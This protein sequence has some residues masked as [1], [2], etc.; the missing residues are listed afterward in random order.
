MSIELTLY[1]DGGARGNPGPAAIGILLCN[2]K[3]HI[4]AQHQDTLGHATNNVAEYCALIA[5]LE[6]AHRHKARRVQC[7]LDSQLVVEQLN[8][9]YKVKHEDMKKLVEEVRKQEKRFEAVT[10]T[11][12][13]R[14]HEHIQ[15]VD[16]FVNDALDRAAK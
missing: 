11:H 2:E 6:L 16:G 15:I 14:T 8:G 7:F 9:R 3:G 10:Y 12:V 1:T 4:V 13:P 5:G